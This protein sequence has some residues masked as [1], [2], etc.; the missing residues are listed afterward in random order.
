M[1][2]GVRRP[3]RRARNTDL[4]HALDAEYINARVVLLHQDRLDRRYVGAYGHEVLCQ[5]GVHRAP[6]ARVNHRMLLERKGY[7]PD[8]PAQVLAA[9][10][11]R[12]DDPPRRESA[13]KPANPDLPEVRSNL[14]FRKYRTVRARRL[15]AWRTPLSH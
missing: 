1:R 6:R 10:Q 5:I 7:A 4:P 11:S 13:N 9:R 2:G 8:H 14:H 3:P 12:V 15:L